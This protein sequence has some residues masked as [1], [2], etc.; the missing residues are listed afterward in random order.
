MISN[1]D[2]RSIRNLDLWLEQI[3]TDKVHRNFEHESETAPS[4]PTPDLGME[5]DTVVS[6]LRNRNLVASYS[7]I[8]DNDITR[9][10]QIALS[11]NDSQLCANLFSNWTN[12]LRTLSELTARD[13]NINLQLIDALKT[14]PNMVVY[15]IRLCP[16]KELASGVQEMLSRSAVSLIK[17]LVLCAN[18][19]GRLVVDHLRL[20][21]LEVSI[22]TF[23]QLSSVVE[24]VAL[25]VCSAET[26]L[27]VLIEAIQPVVHRLLPCPRIHSEYL[28][29]V[30]AGI[31]IDHIEEAQ[32]VAKTSRRA[33]YHWRF[34]HA[35]E[36]K[37]GAAMLKCDY[38]IDAPTTI[39]IV[40]GDHIR[41]T[42]IE[43]PPNLLAT[44]PVSFETLVDASDTGQIL[45]RCLRYPPSFYQQCA[46]KAELYGSFITSKT[47]IDAVTALLSHK[48][49]CCEI[50]S[51]LL[52]SI[53]ELQSSSTT[54]RTMTD[55]SR[56]NE[57]QCQAVKEALTG[58]VTC[59]WGPP[60]TGKTHTIV[61]IIRDSL[62]CDLERRLLVTA[63]THSAVDNIMRQYLGHAKTSGA[64]TGVAFLRV[65]TDV[66]RLYIQVDSTDISRYAKSPRTCVA[67]L[68]MPC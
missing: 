5:S 60:G 19:I 23:D 42:P 63:P 6:L 54:F 34:D 15:F 56:L 7:V 17:A 16:W 3:D 27:D 10:L 46:W 51:Y 26:A 36:H 61:S 2:T 11:S 59:I 20:L 49:A 14:K 33:N 32:G 24:L 35:L 68:A 40:V 44:G 30:L 67:I 12:A 8:T 58:P 4:I 1:T 47:M 41:F 55:L 65:S 66:S 52:S 13:E 62:A 18:T 39:R 64:T 38:R 28:F 53:D 22:L 45:L 31:A 57:S 37:D 48:E 21:L 43:Y 29:K 25:T 9:A 50:S